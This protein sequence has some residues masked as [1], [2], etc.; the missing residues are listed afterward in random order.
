[1][2]DEADRSR[3]MLT[4]GDER[5]GWSRRE[6][7]WTVPWWPRFFL[8]ETSAAL[9]V[10]AAFC[11]LALLVDAPLLD[12][13]D[14]GVTPDPSKAPWYFVG[15]QEL[16][17][18]YPPV[19]AGVA[20]PMLAMVLLLAVPYLRCRSLWP[21]EETPRRRL[22]HLLAGLCGLLLAMLAPAR[23]V[24]WVLLVP[25]FTLAVPMLAPALTRRRGP[26]LVWVMRRTLI[27]WFALWLASAAILATLVGALFRGPGWSWVW[28]WI[29]G[30]YG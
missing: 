20:A 25:T 7:R 12:L 5:S 11:S 18:Y 15:L 13:A 16:L 1:M 24:P 9:L 4:P 14:P 8:L 27:D 19:I 17:H 3:R 22:V 23:H 6:L 10:L 2:A 21:G 29:D 28:P 30:M 26:L